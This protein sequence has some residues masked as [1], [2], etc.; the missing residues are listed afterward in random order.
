LPE[1]VDEGGVLVEPTSVEALAEAM[2]MLLV[3]DALRSELRQR[4]LAQA[5]KFSWRQTALETLAVY[6]K[7]VGC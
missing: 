6:R 1:V 2:E 7:A 4:A 5:A 3:D